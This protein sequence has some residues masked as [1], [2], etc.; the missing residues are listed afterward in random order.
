MAEKVAIL[1]KYLEFAN[2]FA[3]KSAAELSE[4]SQSNQHLINLELYKQLPYGLIYSLGPIELKILKNYIEI[5]LVNS[6]IRLTKF[7]T[8]ALIIFDKKP[9]GSLGL[10]MDY[11]NRAT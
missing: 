7:P 4:H 10:C 5:N 1:T 11:C 9:D 3:K 8:R 2:V 6:F